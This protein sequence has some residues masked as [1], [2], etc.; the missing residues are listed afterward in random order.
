SSMRSSRAFAIVSRAAFLSSVVSC[1][2]LAAAS[3]AAFAFSTTSLMRVS[4]LD[5]QSRH[6]I[7][8]V[9]HF[10]AG[11]FNPFG[12]FIAAEPGDGGYLPAVVVGDAASQR[13]S[14][15]VRHLDH[16]AGMKLAFGANDAGRQK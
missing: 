9:N 16:I 2:I 7:V 13:S 6:P 14:A 8:A 5:H 15:G 10:H 11:D 12:R 3:W 4:L 1:A